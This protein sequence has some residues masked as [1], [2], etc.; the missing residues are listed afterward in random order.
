M[1]DQSTPAN[2]PQPDIT[3]FGE[4]LSQRF[5]NRFKREDRSHV[6]LVIVLGTKLTVAPV[7]DIPGS[8]PPH[9]PQI[10]VS[11]EV[12]LSEPQQRPSLKLANV[13]PS[14]VVTSISTSSS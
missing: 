12:R 7:G 13:C 10:F 2:V 4:A 3:F 9:V 1:R 6:D 5:H 8:L 11:R 14:L